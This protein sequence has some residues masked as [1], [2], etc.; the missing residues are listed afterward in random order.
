MVTSARKKKK[1]DV[2]VKGAMKV[3]GAAGASKNFVEELAETCAEPGE[4]MTS[5]D[6]R[7]SD[8]KKIPFSLLSTRIILRLVW[9]RN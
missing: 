1:V 5:P 6:L 8:I 7:V 3:S 9:L 4:V 2:M